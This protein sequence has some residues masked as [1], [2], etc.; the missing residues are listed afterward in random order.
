MCPNETN[1]RVCVGKYLSDMFPINY[2]FKQGN[3]LSLLF[4]SLPL[5]YAITRVQVKHEG[6]KVS[7]KCCFI[8]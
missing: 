6:L 2:G 3:G 7:G 4:F 8:R 5:H 1:S